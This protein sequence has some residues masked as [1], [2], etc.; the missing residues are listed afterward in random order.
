MWGSVLGSPFRIPLCYTC[1]GGRSLGHRCSLQLNP[2]EEPGYGLS[3]HN[4]LWKRSFWFSWEDLVTYPRPHS[5]H[6]FGCPS[7]NSNLVLGSLQP[8]CS[9]HLMLPSVLSR[10]NTFS[11]T[12]RKASEHFPSPFLGVFMFLS[13]LAPRCENVVKN[14]L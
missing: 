12:K 7:F 1:W 9:A 13:H 8:Q 3:A 10:L 14:S 2:K 6:H 4:A 11:V 5:T